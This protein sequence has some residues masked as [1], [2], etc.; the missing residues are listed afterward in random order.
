MHD[1]P[2]QYCLSSGPKHKT[3]TTDILKVLAI[4]LLN[5]DINKLYHTFLS[6][7]WQKM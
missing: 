2:L 3:I 5:T 6:Q 1:P 4:I 7:A